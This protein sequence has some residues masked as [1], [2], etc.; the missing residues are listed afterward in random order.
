MVRGCGSL[1]ANTKCLQRACKVNKPWGRPRGQ[2]GKEWLF[3]EGSEERGHTRRH[4]ASRS[5]ISLKNVV[6]DGERSC[7]PACPSGRCRRPGPL[8]PCE[9]GRAPRE[10]LLRLRRAEPRLMATR[11]RE[12]GRTARRMEPVG[13]AVSGSPRPGSGLRGAPTP[14]SPWGQ[15]GEPRGRAERPRAAERGAAGSL[16]L[17]LRVLSG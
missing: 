10:A 14:T 15:A 2:T 3:P 17:C 4:A 11:R 5:A 7:G 12:P 16:A 13:P 9:A 1:S 8:T 6:T